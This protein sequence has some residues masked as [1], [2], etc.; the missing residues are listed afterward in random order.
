MVRIG[1]L[2][3]RL[4][5][6][7]YGANLVW[8][9]E[10][11]DKAL[12]SGTPVERV[13]NDRINCIDFVKPPSNK[14]LFR[15]HP[16]EANR[17]IFQLGSASPELAVEAAKLVANDVAGIDLNC[18]CP[19]HFSVH[20]GMGAGLLK[21]QDRL[22]SILDALVNEIG[23]PYKISISCK[24]RLLETKEDTL[25]LVERICDTGVRAITVHCRTTPMRN[26]EPA[27]RSY[28]SEIVGVCRNKDVSILVNGDVLSYN[29]GLDVIEKY[30]VDG[31]LIARAAERN[32]SCFRIEGPLSSFKV[33]EEF[34]KM[35]LEVDNNF[36]N[37]KYCLNQIMQGSF[38]KN[39]RQLA[40]TAKTYEDL[41][42]AF[43]IEYKHSDASSVCP[44]LE[45]EKSLVISFVDL[46]SFLESLLAS[47]ILKQLSRLHFTKIF[48]VSEEEDICKQ[49]DDIHE[50]FL[51]HGIALSLISADNLASAIASAHLVIC[52]EK[53]ESIMNEAVCDQKITIRLP[54][55]SN[56]N[57]AVVECE[58]KSMQSKH[59]L[60][61]IQERIKDLEEKA[62][63]V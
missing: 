15:V 42:K 57:E 18:G 2:P 4:L 19:K 48:A 63:V 30:G 50:K 5:A 28:L 62:Q 9:P 11:V 58:N 61:I 29:D 34:L 56:T 20:A 43:E 37:T 8:G 46:P 31:V 45:K 55:N 59:A 39:V 25:K 17:L 54:I 24:I 41:K 40:Q 53:D 38:R 22:V 3:M 26:T 10:I 51:C 33:A 32:V 12:L 14:V 60:D 7:R 49:L 36:G 23:K 21:N 47:N 16:L 35:A 27:D 13:V 52:M 44:T 6:L 1:E